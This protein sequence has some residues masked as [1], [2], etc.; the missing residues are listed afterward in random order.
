M[1]CTF[2]TRLSRFNVP[3]KNGVLISERSL[4]LCPIRRNVPL[5]IADGEDIT[6][7]PI[8]FFPVP[9]PEPVFILFELICSNPEISS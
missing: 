2:H 6:I 9:L 3:P 4:V 8:P 5:A 1:R 7:F